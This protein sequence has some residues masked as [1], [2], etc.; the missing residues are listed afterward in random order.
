MM[1]AL[2]RRSCCKGIRGTADA[3]DPEGLAKQGRSVS[4]GSQVG[5]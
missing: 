4:G 5:R 2:T 1:L 3:T